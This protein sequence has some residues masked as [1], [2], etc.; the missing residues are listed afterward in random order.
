M[1]AKSTRLWIGLFVVV[2]FLCGL[3]AGV[4]LRPWL[5]IGP[6]WGRFGPPRGLAP[7]PEQAIIERLA[8]QTEL[9]EEQ[10]GRLKEVFDA[11][12]QRFRQIHREVRQRFHTEQEALRAEIAEILTP[13][14]LEERGRLHTEQ[15]ALRA[16]IAEILTPAQLEER[17][18]LRASLQA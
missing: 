15:E 13:A 16:E 17:G 12:R 7:R 2:V 18:R 14:Q 11:R 8:T 3:G 10:R 5:G 6:L 9:S 4:V 1:N